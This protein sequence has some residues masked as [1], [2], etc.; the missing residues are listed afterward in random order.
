MVKLNLEIPEGWLEPEEKWGFQVTRQRKEIW[1][2]ELD[3]LHEL[4]RVCKKHK[5]WNMKPKSRS[6]DLHVFFVYF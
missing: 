6:P 1:A 3:L 2:V 5:F 4:D